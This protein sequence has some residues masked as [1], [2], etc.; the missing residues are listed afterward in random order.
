MSRYDVID[1]TPQRLGR[2]LPAF[3]IVGFGCA[4]HMSLPFVTVDKPTY[5]VSA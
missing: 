5:G 1:L 3:G 4:G 2:A